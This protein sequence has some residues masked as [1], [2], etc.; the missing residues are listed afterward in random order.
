[1]PRELHGSRPRGVGSTPTCLTLKLTG[2]GQMVRRGKDVSSTLVAMS[3]YT[4]N[5]FINQ[6]QE[7]A[8]RNAANAEGTT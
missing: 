6:K 2:S 8:I 3:I 4:N 5:T 1:M 7:T